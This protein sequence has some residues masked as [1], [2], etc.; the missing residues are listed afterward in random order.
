MKD[1]KLIIKELTRVRKTIND[2]LTKFEGLDN[3]ICPHIVS[4][5]EMEIYPDRD[6]NRVRVWFDTQ[7]PSAI[8]HTRFYKGEPSYVW[9]KTNKRRVEFLD[10]LIQFVIE[11]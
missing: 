10:Y 3:Y 4:R 8:L 9:F 1:K 7:Q 11:S 2:S 5:Y 6:I